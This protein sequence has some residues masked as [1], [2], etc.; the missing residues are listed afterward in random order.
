MFALLITERHRQGGAFARTVLNDKICGN[1]AWGT[2]VQENRRLRALTGISSSARLVTSEYWGRFFQSFKARPQ[3]IKTG[4]NSLDHAG[5]LN[6]PWDHD[7]DGA[8]IRNKCTLWFLRASA[9]E[10]LGALVYAT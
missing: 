10:L 8:S 3:P 1:P 6:A 7:S 2:E 9:P 5:G 4:G